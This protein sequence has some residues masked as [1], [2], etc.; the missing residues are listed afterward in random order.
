MNKKDQQLF[1]D[2]INENL[3]QIGFHELKKQEF[4]RENKYIAEILCRAESQGKK[5]LHEKK[6]CFEK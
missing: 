1:I 5:S 2:Q 3:R 4:M 6:E